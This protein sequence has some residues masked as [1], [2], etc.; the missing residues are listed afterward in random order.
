LARPAAVHLAA[1]WLNAAASLRDV[2]AVTHG[3]DRLAAH[4]EQ[5]RDPR[6]R[7]RRIAAEQL[8][9]QPHSLRFIAAA[10]VAELAAVDTMPQLADRLVAATDPLGDDLV[11]E[12]LLAREQTQN[13]L[14]HTRRQA[15][16]A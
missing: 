7:H 4:I 10:I 14:H 8:Q 9:R 3:P 5:S 6:D 11:R 2:V 13:V 16:A 12:F 15:P 1:W